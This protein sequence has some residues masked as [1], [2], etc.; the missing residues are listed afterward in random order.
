MAVNVYLMP[1][2]VSGPK[3]ARLPKYFASLDGLDPTWMDYGLEPVFLVV[4]QDIPALT[5][6]FLVAQSDVIVVP[7]LQQTVGA[8]LA[9]VQSRLEL[10]NIPSGWVQ[11]SHSYGSVVRYAAIFFHLMQR[12]QGMG[13][14]K[15]L[16]GGVTLDTRFNQL[17]AGVQGNLVATAQSFGMDTS[18]LSGASTIREMLKALADQWPALSI[19]V[20]GAIV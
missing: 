8:Q 10:L 2:I 17:T 7:D 20:G 18:S 9:I 16:D 14:A 4:V 1:L 19:S 5:H 13:F 11:S 12:M 15:L 6:T 3:N